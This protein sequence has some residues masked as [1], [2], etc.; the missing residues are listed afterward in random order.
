MIR[1]LSF[2]LVIFS[3]SVAAESPY[4]IKLG[5]KVE[6]V[7]YHLET[8]HGSDGIAVRALACIMSRINQPFVIHKLPWKRAQ[9]E[10]KVGK[11]DG[12]FSASRNEIRDGYAT[13]SEVFLPQER[14]FYTLKEKIRLPLEAY[15]IE[16]IK[17]NVSVGARY[18]S[19]TLHSLKK[20]NY[21]IG[22]APQTQSQLLKMLELGRIGAVLE[23][24]LVF[25][26]LVQKMGKSMLDF[27]QVP[28]KKKNMGV[29][30]GHQFL[31]K[32]PDFLKKF[33]QNVQA[34]SLLSYS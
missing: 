32:H 7:P 28:Q 20:E 1:A 23:N 34:C 30:F 19:N 31:T 33:N 27:Y 15:T 14:I 4:I 17:E 29:Y 5:S 6:W 24:S 25:P 12:F 26:D 3:F 16:Y 9:E 21:N 22:A 10:T 2:C 11:L 8:P 18:G 13:L